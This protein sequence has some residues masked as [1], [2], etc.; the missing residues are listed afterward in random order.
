MSLAQSGPP[1]R[2]LSNLSALLTSHPPTPA[3]LAEWEAWRF[4]NPEVAEYAARVSPFVAYRMKS[5]GHSA[6]SSPFWEDPPG[7]LTVYAEH[8]DLG[9]I[10]GVNVMGVLIDD[11]SRGSRRRLHDRRSRHGSPRGDRRDYQ[12][13]DSP[14]YRLCGRGH[15]RA[16]Y[17][18]DRV[19]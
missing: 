13:D 3:Q 10:S 15:V 4:D 6:A 11:W 18:A 19:S 17:V 5:H 1:L 12:W 7:S 8:P 16:V 9:V 14:D 2:Y